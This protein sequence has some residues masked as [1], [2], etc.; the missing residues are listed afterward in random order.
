[1]RGE[2]RWSE[3]SDVYALGVLLVRLLTGR[4][5]EAG[6]LG[7]ALPARGERVLAGLLAPDPDERTA[8]MGA[9]AEALAAVLAE[10]ETDSAIG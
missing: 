4:A 6:P 5:P 3:R 7:G 10:A 8:D 2:Q 1:M 9:A